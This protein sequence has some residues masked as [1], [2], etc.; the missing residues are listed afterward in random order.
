MSSQTP[1]PTPERLAA[2][3]R[4]QVPPEEADAIGAHICECEPCCE[5][6]LGLSHDDTFVGQLQQARNLPTA[7]RN[8]TPII[9]AAL[10]EHPRY[11]VIDL[12]GTGGMGDVYR[13]THRLMQR[14]VALKVIR[15]DLMTRPE[16]VDRFHREVRTAARLAHPNIVTAYDAEQAGSVHFMVME[17][18]SGGELFDYIVKHGKVR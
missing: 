1:H 11:D 3:N 8:E 16:A 2:Y 7:E 18:V 10:K 5:T 4:G 14:T 12:T 15:R 17:Y 13:A 6:L 9:P